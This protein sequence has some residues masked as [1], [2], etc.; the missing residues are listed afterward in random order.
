MTDRAIP[1][2]RVRQE[3]VDYLRGALED[4]KVKAF[5]ARLDRDPVYQ[6]ELQ[7]AR[8]DVVVAIGE[9]G[10]GYGDAVA[11]EAARGEEAA[12][13]LGLDIFDDDALTAFSR[14][15]IIRS[16]GCFASSRNV[17]YCRKTNISSIGS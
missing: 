9:D 10:G 2:D 14:F 16:S 3:V 8:G 12:V 17:S 4:S 13:D 7:Q 6:Q 15:H 5:E 11:E 1:T